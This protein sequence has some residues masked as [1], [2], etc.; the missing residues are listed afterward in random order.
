MEEKRRRVISG[1]SDRMKELDI[2]AYI[3]LVL[4][5]LGYEDV[6]DDIKEEFIVFIQEWMKEFS[7]TVTIEDNEIRVYDVFVSFDFHHSIYIKFSLCIGMSSYVIVPRRK[8]LQ[9]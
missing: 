8:H 6:T 4:T 9:K 5:A 7:K 1:R 3:N 2:P